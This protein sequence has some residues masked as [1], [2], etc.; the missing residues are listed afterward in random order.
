MFIV[1]NHVDGT[2]DKMPT[3]LPVPPG[4]EEIL[5]RIEREHDVELELE[6]SDVPFVKISKLMNTT[7]QLATEVHKSCSLMLKKLLEEE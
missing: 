7:G 1:A 2:L 3:T 6:A 4:S 5:T